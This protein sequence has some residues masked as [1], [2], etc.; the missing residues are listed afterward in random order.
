MQ[1]TPA[2]VATAVRKT[3]ARL[4]KLGVE[5]AEEMAAQLAV[6][7]LDLTGEFRCFD[8]ALDLAIYIDLDI[9]PP[10]AA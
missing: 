1:Y 6:R 8:A 7:A 3:R 9:A 2:E 4:T 10:R 5:A